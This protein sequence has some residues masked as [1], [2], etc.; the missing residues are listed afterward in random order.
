ME[1]EI[2]P[3][4]ILP[5]S[6]NQKPK[7]VTVFH[8]KTK[9]A[10]LTRCIYFSFS[11]SGYVVKLSDEVK[12]SFVELMSFKKFM[13]GRIFDLDEDKIGDVKHLLNK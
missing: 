8:I 3:L 12:G 10:F 4:S 6:E 9:Y 2:F 1:K 11:S 5:L 13:E 7:L